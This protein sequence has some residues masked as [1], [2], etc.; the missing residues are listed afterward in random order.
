MADM[1]FEE[2]LNNALQLDSAELA[3]LMEHLASALHERLAEDTANESA[4][5]IE[6]FTPEEVAEMLRPGKK[7]TFDELIEQG[8]LGGWADMGI[9]DSVE[10]IQAQRR[11]RWEQL[12]MLNTQE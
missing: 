12:H 3:R 1:P 2:V 8:I 6:A 9:N 4:D 11:K 7:L 5:D 10:W